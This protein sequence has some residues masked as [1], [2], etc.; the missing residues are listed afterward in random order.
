MPPHSELE[1]ALFDALAAYGLPAPVRQLPLPGRD[2]PRGIA[3]GGYLDAKIVLEADGRRW[4][5]RLAAAAKDR[6]RDLQAARVGWQTMRWVY[7][8]VVGDPA[9]VCA[10]VR[11]ARAVRL[12]LF[13]RA[14][15]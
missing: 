7:E 5:D 14:A 2:R 1:R 8:Q 13:R 12:D 6:E 9:E 11:D 4:H 15:A 3:D 10:A